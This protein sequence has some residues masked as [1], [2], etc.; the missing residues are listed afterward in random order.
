MKI[1]ADVKGIRLDKYI[2]QVLPQYSRGFFQKRIKSGRITVNG[3]AASVHYTTKLG[4]GIEIDLEDDIK[5]VEPQDI[6]LE[7][8]FEDGDVIVINKRPGIIVHPACGHR[9][10]T[11][12]NALYGH[13][14]G[15]FNPLL[16]HRLDKDTSG[17]MVVAKNERAKKSLVK[18]FQN[19]TIK[20]VYV[21]AVKGVI[22][23][24]RGRIEAPLGRA[25][26]DRQKIVVGPLAKKEGITEFKVAKRSGGFSVIEVY[27]LT[28]R[29][30]Q[31]RSHMV[32]IG[33]PVLGDRVYGGPENM[34]G[35]TFPRQMLHAK[36]ISFTHPSTGK[37]VEFEAPLPDDMK[38]LMNG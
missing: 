7:I 23:E 6:A 17:V 37:R 38:D 24:E 18:Q 26:G 4:D 20:K 21:A 31:I 32:Y 5:Q 11:L 34:D 13:A 29:T 28:G 10:G 36:R 19:R 30:H 33:H 25:P 27:P 2:A 22:T 14:G 9:N 8:L 15:L 1:I 16:V 35:R 12:L 3:S